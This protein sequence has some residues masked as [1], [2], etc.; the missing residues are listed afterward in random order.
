MIRPDLR[1]AFAIAFA[2]TAATPAAAR[3][4]DP[5]DGSCAVA[6]GARIIVNVV[7]LKDRVGRL[8]LELYPANEAD[9]L[10]DDRD[11]VR[12]GKPFRR[13]WAQMPASGPV[14]L[15]IRA[16][17]AGQWALLFTHDRDGKNKFNFWQD[18]AGFP[19]NTR[20]G[21]SRPKLRQA[22]VN[23]APGGGQITVRAQYLKGLGGFG[24]L[25]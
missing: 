4:V 20:L 8:K 9:F 5:T 23:V 1:I 10:R 15:C 16:P 25:D 24:P 21:R 13:I 6:G 18:G 12:E 17:N 7:G 22:L 14:T 19:S 2:L 11:L 3:I